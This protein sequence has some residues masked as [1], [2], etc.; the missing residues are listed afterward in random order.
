MSLRT[1]VN[2]HVLLSMIN[3]CQWVRNP[4]YYNPYL[5]QINTLSGV[6]PVGI[7]FTPNWSQGTVGPSFSLKLTCRNNKVSSHTYAHRQNCDGTPN[8]VH[9]I[10][11][12]NEYQCDGSICDYVHYRVYT[13][14]CDFDSQIQQ[15]NEHICPLNQ[16]YEGLFSGLYVEWGCGSEKDEWYSIM[17]NATDIQCSEATVGNNT[18]R[19]G[20]DSTGTTYQE[21]LHCG[22]APNDSSLDLSKYTGVFVFFSIVVI[23][24]I[25]YGI[26]CCCK[27]TK[28]KEMVRLMNKNPQKD[29][30][31]K[32]KEETNNDQSFGLT[33]S[34]M[35]TANLLEK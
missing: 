7:C 32:I 34:L 3:G 2:L 18:F 10:N 13:N 5:N 11:N 19:T 16:C 9:E 12:G 20:C 17:Y 25:F 8:D 1:F 35:D 28:K 22:A 24:L 26:W 6:Y 15:Y 27:E 29:Q 21:I 30:L 4:D 14:Q 23:L 33:T 31:S